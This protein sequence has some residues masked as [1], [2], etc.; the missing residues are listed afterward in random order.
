MKKIFTFFATL[1]LMLVFAR[2]DNVIAASAEENYKWY[3]AQCHG[4]AGKGDGANSKDLPV[5]P[6]NHTNPEDMKKL[7]DA[8]IENVVK[9]GGAATSKSTTMPPFGS[10]FSPDEIKEMVKHLRKLCKC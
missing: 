2:F 8:D 10:T 3:C 7:T 5:T 6:R 4:A 1:L 9:S